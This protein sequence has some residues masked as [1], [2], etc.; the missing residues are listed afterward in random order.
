ME[1]VQKA[2]KIIKN[3]GI[4]VYPTDTVFGIACR[5]DD[6][7]AIKRLFTIKQRSEKQSVPVLVDSIVMAEKYLLPISRKVKEQLMKPYW[8]G[9]L[10]IVLPCD[11]RKVPSLI[12]GGGNTLGV[13]IPDNKLLQ[14]IIRQVGIPITG[15]SANFHGQTTPSKKVELN[16]EFI[17][18]VDF[19]LPGKCNNNLSSTVIDCSVSPW[20]ILREG[21]VKIPLQIGRASC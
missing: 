20:K 18:L 21:V 12:R 14:E 17:K 8:P 11:T 13:R 3:G 9:G 5:I 2:I 10:T 7:V 4:V 19:V 15:T 6:E 16:P 1:D